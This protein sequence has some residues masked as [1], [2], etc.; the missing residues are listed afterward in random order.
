[1]AN[2]AK[3]LELLFQSL[4]AHLNSKRNSKELARSFG[5]QMGAILLVQDHW[6][7]VLDSPRA[8]RQ[9]KSMV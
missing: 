5:N 2:E 6:F 3:D 7:R 4:Y 9:R 1:M 8:V